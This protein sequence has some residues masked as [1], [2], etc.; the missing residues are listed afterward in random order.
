MQR[1]NIGLIEFQR[2]R[3]ESEKEHNQGIVIENYLYVGNT[4]FRNRKRRL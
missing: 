1:S 2:E 4:Q 3:I